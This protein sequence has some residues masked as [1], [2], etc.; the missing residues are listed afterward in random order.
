MKNPLYEDVILNDNWTQ[1]AQAKDDYLWSSLVSTVTSFWKVR[2]FHAQSQKAL[3]EEILSN[4]NF[5]S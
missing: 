4:Q 1:E 3:I 2:V 5:M